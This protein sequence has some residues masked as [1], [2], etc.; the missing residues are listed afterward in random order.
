MISIASPVPA[1]V[2]DAVAGYGGRA[3]LRR[4]FTIRGDDDEFFTEH[5]VVGGVDSP[6]ARKLLQASAYWRAWNESFCKALQPPQS[7][8][9]SDNTV[10]KKLPS[11]S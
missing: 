11:R 9:T 4:S 1:D 7:T 5:V 3:G 8:Q 6:Y 10:P 2:Y